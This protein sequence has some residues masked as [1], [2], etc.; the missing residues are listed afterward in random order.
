MSLNS[1]LRIPTWVKCLPFILLTCAGLW[2]RTYHLED[3]PYGL[4]T[5]QAKVLSWGTSALENLN[6][7]V[8]TDEETEF[9]ALS[10][11]FFAG[12]EKLWV[13]EGYP[14][15]GARILALF[16]SVVDLVLLAMLLLKMGPLRMWQGVA[17]LATC[18]WAIFY[19][20]IVGPC[21]G[22]SSLLLLELWVMGLGPQLVILSVGLLYYS[23]F[24]L[25]W[26]YELIWAIIQKERRRILLAL[27]PAAIL[28][29]LSFL[30]N[31]LSGGESLRGLYNIPVTGLAVTSRFGAW[32]SLWFTGPARVLSWPIPEF[33][34]DPVSFGFA[35]LLGGGPALG[36][37]LMP[38]FVLTLLTLPKY[39]K[40]FDGPD[41]RA[42]GIFLFIFFALILSPTYSHG[43]IILP[44]VPFLVIRVLGPVASKKD[45]LS[46]LFGLA[47]WSAGLAGI[48]QSYVILDG[49]RSHGDHEVVFPDRLRTLFEK[50]LRSDSVGIPRSFFSAQNFHPARYLAEVE[51]RAGHPIYAYP[52]MEPQEIL[53]LLAVYWRETKTQI[54]YFDIQDTALPWGDTLN[55]AISRQRL[56]DAETRI[57]QQYEVLER[58]DIYVLD[59]PVARRYLIKRY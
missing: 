27:I 43:L 6:F 1:E 12:A 53:D 29:L 3:V 33:V 17:L 44:L 57:S 31:G 36:L 38:L 24:R 22:V 28:L 16:L 7:K 9:E 45:A 2:L 37:G 18:P 19:A 15:L 51:V 56:Q 30:T 48:T 35:R 10:S 47:V 20:R 40:S 25:V 52:A 5:D 41:L 8:Y 32:L 58:K 26:I 13:R 50:N 49:L 21:V 23:L 14:A 34:V 55:A 59:Q 39:G 11:Y 54:V 4:D 46:Y 42:L